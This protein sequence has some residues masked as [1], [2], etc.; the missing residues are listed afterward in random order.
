MTSTAPIRGCSPVWALHV[1]LVDRGTDEPLEGVGDGA[2]RPGQG[3]DR[4]VVA[5]V[6]GPV[7]E[8]DAGD[9]ADRRREPFDDVE[10]ATLGDIRDRLDEPIGGRSDIAVS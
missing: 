3:E 6:A 8:V 4:A 1:D 9:R 10:P 7:E 2:G 5:G